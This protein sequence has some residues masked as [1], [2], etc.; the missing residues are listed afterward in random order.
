MKKCLFVIPTLP[1]P[2]GRVHVAVYGNKH[3]LSLVTSLVPSRTE[4][5]PL[6]K[7]PGF[8]TRLSVNVGHVVVC[9]GLGLRP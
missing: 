8:G 5:K 3:L 2:G 6:R 1:D 9:L 4:K 7:L